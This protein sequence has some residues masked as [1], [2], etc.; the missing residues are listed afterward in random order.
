MQNYMGI[1]ASNRGEPYV[2]L[3]NNA[4][5]NGR[6]NTRKS[7]FITLPVGENEKRKNKTSACVLKIPTCATHNIT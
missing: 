3:D 5:A 7:I 6:G 4:E 2:F 1:S